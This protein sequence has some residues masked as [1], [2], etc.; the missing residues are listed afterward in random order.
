MAFTPGVLAFTR[1]IIA[2][3]IGEQVSA[4][5]V[6]I[7]PGQILDA[8]IYFNPGDF[9]ITFATPS[10]L[11]AQPQSYDLQSIL[12]HE[13]GHFLSFSHSAIWSAMMFPY[14]HMPG[15]FSTPRPSTQQPDASRRPIR[16]RSR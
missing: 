8:D 10:A 16:S 5:Q 14:T 1:V 13:L 6:S 7:A 12:A 15:T 11:G 4:G 2:D 3:R 9:N